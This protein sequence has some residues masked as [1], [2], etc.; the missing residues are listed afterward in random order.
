MKFW[1]NCSKTTNVDFHQNSIDRSLDMFLKCL[2]HKGIRKIWIFDKIRDFGC[3]RL[4]QV[5]GS[6][7]FVDYKCQVYTGTYIIIMFQILCLF[8]KGLIINHS[9][10]N[11]LNILIS[12]GV[13]L[14]DWVN[15]SNLELNWTS[16]SLL[17]LSE[18]WS[19]WS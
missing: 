1:Q 13:N 4:S 9:F 15:V 10:R 17:K 19:T 8:S 16:L 12:S 7:S 3:I 14:S 5:R 6:F 11:Q 2:R 18:F